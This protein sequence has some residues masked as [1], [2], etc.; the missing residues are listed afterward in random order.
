MISQNQ[1]RFTKLE[2]SLHLY[3]KR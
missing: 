3:T 1:Q 2:L